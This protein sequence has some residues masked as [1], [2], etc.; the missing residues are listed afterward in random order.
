MTD[1]GRTLQG[2]YAGFVSRLA[3]FLIDSV[4][5]GATTLVVTWATVS[6][7]VEI[8]IE[9]RDCAAL[10][11]RYPVRAWLCHSLIV[12]GPVASTAFVVLYGLLFWATTGQTPGKAV[13]GVR[14]VRVS[15]RPMNLITA[16]RRSLGYVLS[17]ASIGLG[18]LFILSDDR[19]QG[20]HDKIAGTVVI[21][22][23]EARQNE[24]FLARVRGGFRR[25]SKHRPQ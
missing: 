25:P 22:S 24:R 15:G 1:A 8:G 7:L 12:V 14:I 4:V 11:A 13:M 3:G 5:I 2:Q 19:R 23:W 21:Y 10:E 6:L 18:F 9:I 16:G 17:F 20:W